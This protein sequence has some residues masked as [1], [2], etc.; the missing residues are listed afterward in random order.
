MSKSP[1]PPIL[2]DFTRESFSSRG[3]TRDVYC[4]GHGPAVLV[5]SEAPG[6]TPLLAEFSRRVADRGLRAVMP[7]LFGRDGARRRCP[8]TPV[9]REI[10]VSR[11]FTLFAKHQAS[12]VTSWLRDLARAEHER[13]G[14]PGVGSS[15]CA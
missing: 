7:H 11:E 2:S 13:H 1:T 10:C 9:A 8:S 15:A 4:L 14:G 6:I 3:V 5:I 12:P